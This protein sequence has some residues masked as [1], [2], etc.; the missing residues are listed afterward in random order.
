MSL[1]DLPIDVWS[2]IACFLP[3]EERFA[4][5]RSLRQAMILRTERSAFHTMSLFVSEAAQLEQKQCATDGVWPERP[6]WDVA[7]Q[8]LLEE[9]GFEKLNVVR[10]L[11]E[12]DGRFE[13]AFS[14]LLHQGHSI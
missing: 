7:S 3:T 4:A 14:H 5:F 10:A 1:S 11:I 8:Q 9:M 13:L 6:T 2:R 12:T